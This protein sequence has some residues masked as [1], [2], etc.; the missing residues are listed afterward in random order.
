M[1]TPDPVE[2]R[3]KSIRGA[4]LRWLTVVPPNLGTLD[5]KRA[6]CPRSFA[7]DPLLLPQPKMKTIALLAAAALAGLS[8][9]QSGQLP[10]CAVSFP[11]SRPSRKT[12]T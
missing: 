6:N 4:F 7:P 8:A 1:A 5:S 2:R 12:A 11:Y 9:A 3:H 10:T